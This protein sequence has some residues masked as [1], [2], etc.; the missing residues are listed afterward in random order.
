M[1]ARRQQ[2]RWALPWMVAG[3]TALLVVLFLF[4]WGQSGAEPAKHPDV[5]SA[6]PSLLRVLSDLP[7]AHE[8]VYDGVIVLPGG[9]WV[10]SLMQYR[11]PDTPWLLK[12]DPDNDPTVLIAIE[13]LI[14]SAKHFADYCGNDP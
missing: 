7:H 4:L 3:T 6:D 10:Q 13:A 9:T 5:A 12:H 14:V 1:H 11:D 2:S 8:E